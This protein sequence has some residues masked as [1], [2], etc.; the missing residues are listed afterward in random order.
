M[1]QKCWCWLFSVVVPLYFVH[2]FLLIRML[3]LTRE[4]EERRQMMLSQILSAEA[5][6]RRKSISK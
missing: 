2:L 4:A 5:R 3:N 1:M 6:E